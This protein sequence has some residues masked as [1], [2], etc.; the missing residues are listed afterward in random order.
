MIRAIR[1]LWMSIQLDRA[2]RARRKA[3]RVHAAASRRGV[4]TYWR[5]SGQRCREMFGL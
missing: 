1:I 2:L 3:A 5:K 4:S